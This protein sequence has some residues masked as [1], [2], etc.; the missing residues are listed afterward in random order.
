MN[1]NELPPLKKQPKL[2]KNKTE[3][4]SNTDDTIKEIHLK[5]TINIDSIKRYF[6]VLFK[7][8]SVK[9]KTSTF[10]SERELNIDNIILFPPF[11]M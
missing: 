7:K 8:T 3:N 5:N 2:V 10:V 6:D 11:D 1:F 9:K 4:A